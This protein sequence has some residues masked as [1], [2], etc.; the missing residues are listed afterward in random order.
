MLENLFDLSYGGLAIWIECLFFKSN[1]FICAEHD[2]C[3][4]SACLS[5]FACM[6]MDWM[7]KAQIWN[8]MKCANKMH[9]YMTRGI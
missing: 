6:R 7:T 8:P 3:A 9:I 1:E 2:R 5:G 4:L